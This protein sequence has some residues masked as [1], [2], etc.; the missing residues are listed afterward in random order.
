VFVRGVDV[1]SNRRVGDFQT[2]TSW[3]CDC[4]GFRPITGDLSDA[5]FA[6]PGDDQKEAAMPLLRVVRERLR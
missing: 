3:R 5:S 4:V 1:G 2:G 6:A